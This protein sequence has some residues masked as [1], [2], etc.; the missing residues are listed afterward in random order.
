MVPILGGLI[1]A[2]VPGC[3]APARLGAAAKVREA[4]RRHSEGRDYTVQD[5]DLLWFRFPP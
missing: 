4:G 2:E 3:T 5:G 1:R